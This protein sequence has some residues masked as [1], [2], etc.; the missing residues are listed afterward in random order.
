LKFYYTYLSFGLIDQT[1]LNFIEMN[2]V[3]NPYTPGAGVP[4]TFLAGRDDILNSP[5][6]GIF[7]PD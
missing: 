2:A 3:D 6:T 1:L 7:V 5:S 4:P